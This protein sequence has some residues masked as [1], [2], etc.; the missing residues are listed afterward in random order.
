MNTEGQFLHEDE[1]TGGVILLDRIFFN[2]DYNR[3][4]NYLADP[5]SDWIPVFESENNQLLYTKLT[6]IL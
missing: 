1:I 6:S 4:P 5:P 3:I 2:P